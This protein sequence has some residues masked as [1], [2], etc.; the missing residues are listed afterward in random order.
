MGYPQGTRTANRRQDFTTAEARPPSL[1]RAANTGFYPSASDPTA[2]QKVQYSLLNRAAISQRWGVN[3]GLVVEA[4]RHPRE[5]FEPIGCMS[6]YFSHLTRYP[7]N[8]FWI[9]CLL[10]RGV[11]TIWLFRVISSKKENSVIIYSPSCRF[12][13][14]RLPFY[15]QNTKED[16]SMKSERFLSLH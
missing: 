11:G 13:P 6:A 7:L 8:S 2:G 16:I 3:F 1:W 4:I 15:I 12:K 14:I 9:K 10:Y 5:Q